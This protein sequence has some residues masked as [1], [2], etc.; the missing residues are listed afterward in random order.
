VVESIIDATLSLWTAKGPEELSLRSIAAR[1][2]VNYGLVHRHFGSKEAVVRAAMDRVIK[3]AIANIKGTKD[4]EDAI[5]K[6]LPRSTGAHARLL[7]WAIL[8]YVVD[9]VLPDDDAFLNRLRELA[10]VG[11]DP[12]S[13]DSAEAQA[14]RVGSLI[15]MLYGWRLF[16]PY[17]VRGLGLESLGHKELDALIR[18]NML[19]TLKG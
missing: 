12:T 4:L 3:N 10:A 7:A 14:V 17:L 16:E 6:V 18:E 1:A 13:A 15:A 11:P 5:D 2:E 9:D 19:R 8:Q